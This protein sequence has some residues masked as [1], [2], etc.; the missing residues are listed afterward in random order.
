VP[1]SGESFTWKF[2]GER[3]RIDRLGGQRPFDHLIA[4]RV[5]HSRGS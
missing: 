1:A 4:D 3:R 2:I 5:G